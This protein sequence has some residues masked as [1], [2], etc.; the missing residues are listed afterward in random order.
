[1]LRNI[2]CELTL[3]DRNDDRQQ[4][5]KDLMWFLEALTQRNQDYLR[6]RPSTPRLYKS[7]VKWSAPKQLTGDIDEVTI[8]KKFLGSSANKRVVQR[9]LEKIQD[10]LGGEHFCDIGVILELGEIDC[11]GLACWRVAE[12]RQMGIPARPFM[13]CR[14]RPGGGTT[15]HALV[16]W[17]PL[18]PCNYETSE[19]PSL[20]LGMY[21]PQKKADRDLEIQKND[22][23]CDI[24]KKYG[25]SALRP[26]VS[27]P[28]AA[29]DGVTFDEAVN[30]LLGKKVA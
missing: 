18:G 29:F 8:L 21:Q 17:P 14:E 23:R 2:W 28:A 13:T 24:L 15:Y 6:Q 3:F 10:V 7:G 30:D 27:S 4:T 9:V 11:D 22:E 16:I 12:L 5:E 25:L 20:L 1:M 26:I 19:D